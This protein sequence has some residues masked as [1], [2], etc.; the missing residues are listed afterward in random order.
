MSTIS[1]PNIF[2][3][4]SCLVGLCT[5]YDGQI[6][7]DNAC[8]SLIK[9]ALWIPVCPEQLGGLPTPRE[10]A[11]ISG[12]D[13]QQVLAG[14]ANVLTKSGT[15]VTSQF[16]KGAEQVLEIARSQKITAVILKSK[17]PSCAV[18]GTTGVTAALLLEHGFD[19]Q[20]Y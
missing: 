2:L 13:G 9:N 12:G 10:A 4:S 6:K 19:V 8:I 20:E 17:S 15:D 18:T 11:D 5:R 1:S 16:I 7:P 3:V 14:K